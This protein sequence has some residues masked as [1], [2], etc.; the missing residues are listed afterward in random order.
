VT[1]EFF[2]VVADHRKIL[3]DLHAAFLGIEI[4]PER[5]LVVLADNCSWRLVE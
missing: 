1:A 5:D 3:G 4:H 2:I